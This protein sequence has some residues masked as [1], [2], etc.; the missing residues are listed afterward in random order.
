MPGLSA[1]EDA[2]TQFVDWP[3]AIS[4]AA[5]GSV[6][7]IPN[8]ARRQIWIHRSRVTDLREA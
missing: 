8:T 7:A 4:G 3:I 1:D 6:P 2:K 5:V